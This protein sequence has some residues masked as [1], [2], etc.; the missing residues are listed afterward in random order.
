M[1]LNPVS[2]PRTGKNKHFQKKFHVS[3]GAYDY[4]VSP[5]VCIYS[6]LGHIISNDDYVQRHSPLLLEPTAATVM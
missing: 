4:T 6:Q 5:E 3:V 1:E 2:A